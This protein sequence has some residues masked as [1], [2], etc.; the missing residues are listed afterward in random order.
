[1][2]ACV[3]CMYLVPVNSEEGIGFSKN[4]IT[5]GCDLLCGNQTQFH[6]RGSKC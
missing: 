3:P 5:S 6:S 4:E 2:P 1:M